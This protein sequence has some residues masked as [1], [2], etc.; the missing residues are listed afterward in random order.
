M[1]LARRSGDVRRVL[2][3]EGEEGMIYWTVRKEGMGNIR[4]RKGIV[5]NYRS[6]CIC[7]VWDDT[8]LDLTATAVY[9]VSIDHFVWILLVFESTWC[10]CLLLP[11]CDL[12]PSSPRRGDFNTIFYDQTVCLQLRERD[13]A[14]SSRSRC[15][16]VL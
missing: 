9:I 8:G 10:P 11:G 1:L 5:Y 15:L 6:G 4:A 3:C 16:V 12:L 7:G 14:R 2:L 13:S